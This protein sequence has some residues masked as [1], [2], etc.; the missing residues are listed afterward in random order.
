MFDQNDGITKG[1]LSDK[2]QQDIDACGQSFEITGKAV[3]DDM[4]EFCALI[5]KEFRSIDM[6]GQSLKYRTGQGGSYVQLDKVFVG[7]GHRLL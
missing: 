7:T 1:P 5:H 6:H 4:S 3:Y 2:S